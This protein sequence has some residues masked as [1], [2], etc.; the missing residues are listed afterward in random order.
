MTGVTVGANKRAVRSGRTGMRALIPIAV[1]LGCGC[2]G[3]GAKY[4]QPKDMGD[5]AAVIAKLGD[6]RARAKTFKAEVEK[7]ADRYAFALA[8]TAG[9]AAR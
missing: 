1:V 5:A 4:P 8:K 2:P 7:G 9:T 3:G 6:A